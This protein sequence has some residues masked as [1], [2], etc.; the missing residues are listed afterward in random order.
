MSRI[1][2]EYRIRRNQEKLVRW[3]VWRLPK[4]LVMW[5]YYRVLA[6]ATTGKYGKTI[7]PEITAMDAVDRWMK[8]Y[9]L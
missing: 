8:D 4:R 3:I 6:H 1:D 5:A 7:V 9:K 2:F